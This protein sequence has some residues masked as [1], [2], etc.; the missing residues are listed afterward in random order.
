MRVAAVR[1]AGGYDP[2]LIAGEEPELCLRMRRLGWTISRI[3]AEMTLH[4]AAMTRFGQWWRRMLRAGHA[5][6]EGAARHGRGPERHWVRETRSNWLWGLGVPF[7]GLALA[8]P[9]G[10]I[11]LLLLLS[12]PVLAVRIYLGSRRRGLSV[13]RGPT[14]RRLLHP[15]QNSAGARASAL[16]DLPRGRP[17]ERHHRI[18]ECAPPGRLTSPSPLGAASDRST[19]TGAFELGD[20]DLRHL[21]H[22]LN[23]GRI[24]HQLR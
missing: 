6:A 20:V 14:V 11:S 4:D 3:D 2:E 13:P 23:D 7:F 1:E 22:R 21:H 10:G 19:A 9:T 24:S 18:Q 17:F 15:R 5:Y 16:L 12:Y 8:A